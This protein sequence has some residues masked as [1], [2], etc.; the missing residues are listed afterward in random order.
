LIAKNEGN[1]ALT[2]RDTLRAW[3]DQAHRLS[4]ARKLHGLKG[5]EFLQFA[6]DIGIKGNRAFEIERLD[7]HRDVVFTRVAKLEKEANAKGIDFRWPGWRR[8]LEI[9]RP[10]RDR[11]AFIENR[12]GNPSVKGFIPNRPSRRHEM[13]GRSDLPPTT[14][15]YIP[16]PDDGD[17]WRTPDNL[18]AFL[19]SHYRFTVDVA[20]TKATAKV[21]RFYDRAKDGL[22]QAWKGETVWLNP[23]YSQAAKWV[24]KAAQEAAN[25][26]IVVGCL[27]NRSATKWYRDHVVPHALIV[28]LHGRIPFY[29]DDTGPRIQMS[30]APF[31][32]ILAIWPKSAGNR[33]RKFTQP[34]DVVLMK[35]PG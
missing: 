3:F 32:T 20:A 25:G 1:I 19:H 7:G 5:A 26:A 28:Q 11:H 10:H 2:S 35:I 8:A 18:F 23:P 17:E 21:K 34:A 13:S 29:R 22:R 6:V 14:P 30:T 9:A 24:E 27:A 4:L 15:G 12:S 33:L 16:W 31:A